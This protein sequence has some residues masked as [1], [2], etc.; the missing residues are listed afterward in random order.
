MNYQRIYDQIIERAKLEVQGRILNRKKWKESKGEEGVYYESHHIIPKCLGGTGRAYQWEHENIVLLT[1]REHFLCHWLLHRIYPDSRSLL[2]A[3]D[4]MCVISPKFN[5]NR[6]I[7]S[8]RVVQEILE[9]KRR[10]GKGEDFKKRMSKRF[11]GV[12]RPKMQCPHCDKVGGIGNMERWHFDNCLKKPGNENVVRKP[13]Y[14]G[15]RKP[16]SG[17]HSEAALLAYKEL[18][19]KRKVKV[20][21]TITGETYPS[22]TDC[23]SVLNIKDKEFNERIIK[24]EFIKLKK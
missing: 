20:L 5:G 1:A 13:V 12:D 24:G 10:L 16:F 22:I 19:E 3:F 9:A 6:V 4:Q 18:A 21:N 17:Y 8:S 7:P 14:A 15:P 2:Y 11:L 23:K